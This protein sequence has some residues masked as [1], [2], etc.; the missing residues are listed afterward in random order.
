MLRCNC[1]HDRAVDLRVS[2]ANDIPSRE[3]CH[4]ELAVSSGLSRV[5]QRVHRRQMPRVRVTESGKKWGWG[6]ES[7][8][9]SEAF[10]D[11]ETRR[12]TD[13]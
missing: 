4:F 5:W 7:T 12:D 13:P 2:E 8:G 9:R 11:P 3:P 6:S 1:P 10:P